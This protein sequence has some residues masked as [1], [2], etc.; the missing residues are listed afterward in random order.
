MITSK[1]PRVEIFSRPRAVVAKDT[2]SSMNAG[3]IYGYAGLVDGV[4]VATHRERSQERPVVA[5]GRLARFGH[6][7]FCGRQTREGRLP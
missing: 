2:I 4:A 5:N 3:L 1:L 6:G 7:G